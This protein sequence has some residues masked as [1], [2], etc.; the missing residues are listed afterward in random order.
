MIHNQVWDAVLPVGAD[1]LELP[2]NCMGVGHQYTC[3]MN[4]KR[5]YRPLVSLSKL[6]YGQNVSTAPY[7]FF[8]RRGTYSTWMTPSSSCHEVTSH[9]LSS[10]SGDVSVPVLSMVVAR[11]SALRTDPM[12]VPLVVLFGGGS[13]AALLGGEDGMVIDLRD[14]FRPWQVF[15]GSVVGHLERR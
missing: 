9:S 15:F 6:R 7:C 3:I 13:L 2:R 4:M 10:G 11:P 14:R 5:R 12:K 8:G 1:S